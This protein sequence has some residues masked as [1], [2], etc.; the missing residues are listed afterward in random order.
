VDEQHLDDLVDMHRFVGEGC[1]KQGGQ[2]RVSAVL[3]CIFLSGFIMQAVAS[4][5]VFKFV[6]IVNE[7]NRLFQDIVVF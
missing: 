5:D 2:C 7:G 3:C 6:K 4:G 1:Q